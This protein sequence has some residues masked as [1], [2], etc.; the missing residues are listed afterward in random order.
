MASLPNPNTPP[1]SGLR[2]DLRYK[3]PKRKLTLGF[4]MAGS[5]VKGGGILS[6][7]AVVIWRVFFW[8]A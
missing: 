3:S 4:G 5:L 6:V 7:A 8:S 1:D 2:F